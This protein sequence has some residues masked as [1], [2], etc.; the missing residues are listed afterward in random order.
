MYPFTIFHASAVTHRRY[1]LY[2]VSDAEREQWRKVLENAIAVR[3]ARQ[4]ANMVS[5]FSIEICLVSCSLTCARFVGQW[6]APHTINESYFKLSGTV[7]VDS[8]ARVTGKIK[9]AAVLSKHLVVI[10]V[11]PTRLIF[12]E[13]WCFCFPSERGQEFCRCGMLKWYIRRAAG[14]SRYGL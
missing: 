5:V 11:G 2:A 14:I 9:C 8:N 1:T 6:F 13:R 4:E 10:E 7:P 3:K 12:V